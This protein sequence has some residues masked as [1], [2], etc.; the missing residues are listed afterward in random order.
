MFL[1]VSSAVMREQRDRLQMTLLNQKQ[2]IT[3][4]FILHDKKQAQFMGN[5]KK[6]NNQSIFFLAVH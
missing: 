6:Y 3:K 2:P 5:L 4:I 1:S